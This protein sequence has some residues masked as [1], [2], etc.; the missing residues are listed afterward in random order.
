MG[1]FV[2]FV[3]KAH[4]LGLLTMVNSIPASLAL[5]AANSSE[6]SIVLYQ[7]PL[8]E[9]YSNV[10]PFVELAVEKWSEDAYENQPRLEGLYYDR[11]G[12]LSSQN[13]KGLFINTFF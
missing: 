6:N 4:S 5:T 12:R 13:H 7:S 11:Q 9:R 10:V 2:P 1:F 3:P 8:P